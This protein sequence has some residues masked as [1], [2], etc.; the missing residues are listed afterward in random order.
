MTSAAFKWTLRSFATRAPF[1]SF[2]IEFINGEQIVVEHPEAVAYWNEIAM[3]RD[4]E[5]SFQVL[6]ADGVCRVYDS[7][8][9]LDLS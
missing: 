2:V 3:F 1:T 4:Q 6:S 7:G 9:E 8:P 5:G